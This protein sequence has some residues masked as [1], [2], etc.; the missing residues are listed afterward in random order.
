MTTEEIKQMNLVYDEQVKK[1][2]ITN[3]DGAIGFKVGYESAHQ[4]PEQVKEKE[5]IKCYN[6]DYKGKMTSLGYICPE[7]NCDN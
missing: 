4:H 6:C 1:G 2:V 5:K 7:C 3:L